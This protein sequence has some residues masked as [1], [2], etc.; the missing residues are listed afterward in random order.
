MTKRTKIVATL[1]SLRYDREFISSLLEAGV[2][3]FRLNTAHQTPEEM[4]EMIDKLREYAP[5]AALL[6]DTKGPELRTSAHG[7]DLE[8]VAGQPIEILGDIEGVSRG[9]V[10]YLTSDRFLE[11]ICEGNKVLID[12]G[13]LELIVTAKKQNSVTCVPQT[14]GII[15]RRK[16]VNIPGI[17]IDLPTLSERDEQFLRVAARKDVRFIAHSFVRTR[18]DIVRVQEFLR[19]EG[20]EAR[21][22]AKIENQQGID[23]IDQILDHAYGIMVARGDLG[24]EIPGECVPPA[25]R[26]IVKKCIERESASDTRGD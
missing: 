23:N 16:S 25:Q 9:N 20:S 5:D 2:N 7:D 11:T 13:A 3:V 18:E 8:V 4:G 19:G 10:L 14:D 22:I 6:V 21:I 1:S 24:I 26:M 12:D 17:P 15:K